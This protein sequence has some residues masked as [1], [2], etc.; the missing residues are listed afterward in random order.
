MSAYSDAV[1]AAI[2]LCLRMVFAFPY[3]ALDTLIDLAV[4]Q[5]HFGTSLFLKIMVRNYCVQSAYRLFIKI[6]FENL[7][8][9][10]LNLQAFALVT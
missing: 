4:I 5:I 7:C 2:V 10:S 3:G 8:K 9:S 6:Y 1:Q